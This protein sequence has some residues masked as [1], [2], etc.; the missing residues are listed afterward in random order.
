MGTE[1]TPNGHQIRPDTS[2]VHCRYAAAIAIRGIGTGVWRSGAA[3]M[4]CNFNL[5]GCPSAF[6]NAAGM[7]YPTNIGHPFSLDESIR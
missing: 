2:R 4:W 7:A 6:E 1:W 5:I 3:Q